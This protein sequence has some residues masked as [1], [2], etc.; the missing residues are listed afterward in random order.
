MC[1]TLDFKS[2]SCYINPNLLD[3]F[4]YVR[5]IR[6]FSVKLYRLLVKNYICKVNKINA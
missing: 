6:G 2:V 5:S 4:I 1:L 3:D